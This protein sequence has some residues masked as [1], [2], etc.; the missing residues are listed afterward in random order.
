MTDQAT[1]EMPGTQEAAPAAAP[2]REP[3]Q[4][5]KP[6]EAAAPKKERKPRTVGKSPL[7]AAGY[8]KDMPAALKKPRSS[9][10]TRPPPDPT[11]DP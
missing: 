11:F 6:R 3:R 9:V 4:K 2:A 8:G 1:G 7:L 5:R 10:G